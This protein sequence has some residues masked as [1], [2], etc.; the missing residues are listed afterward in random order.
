MA[1][2]E[3]TIVAG[4][5]GSE[6]SADA[7]SWAVRDARLRGLSV[8]ICHAWTP[9]YPVPAAG[10]T[11][12]DGPAREHA[13]EVISR[14]A[15]HARACDAAVEI[16]PV[17]VCGAAARALC[18]QSAGADMLVVGSR[19]AGGLAG[20]LLGSVS[21]QVAAHARVPVTVVR[22][23]WR[24]VPG[25]NPAP[26]VVGVDGSPGSQAALELAIMEAAL[27]DVPLVAVCALADAAGAVGVARSIEADFG[28]AIT[29]AQADHPGVLVRARV[30]QGSPRT[31]LLAAAAQAQLLVV[32]ARGRGGLRDMSLGSVSVAVL[33]H[34]PCPV[35]VVRPAR[36]SPGP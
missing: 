4:Y 23:H 25:D 24:P 35:S 34:A 26:V 10:P 8:I 18:A 36:P 2:A 6:A 9:G 15:R 20:L 30:E 14:G 3:Q 33:H 17:L 11:A 28:S 13:E 12:S 5:D 21:F 27:R 22:S 19:G 29:R 1:A 16:R 7:V 32:G 31:A